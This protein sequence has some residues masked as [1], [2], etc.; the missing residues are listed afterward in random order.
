MK[1]I[2][3]VF[4]PPVSKQMA[5]PVICAKHPIRNWFQMHS[6][7]C[8]LNSVIRS[9]HIVGGFRNAYSARPSYT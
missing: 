6:R 2:L 3:V 9:S 1:S 4:T 5:Q 8:R 7:T